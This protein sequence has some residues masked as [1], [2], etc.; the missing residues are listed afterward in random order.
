MLE[1]AAQ[2]ALERIRRDRD[3]AS[4]RLRPML[5]HI[6]SHVFAP[7]LNV[8][9][10]KKACGIRDNSIAILFHSQIGQ[11][12]KTY[13]S[14]RRLET[15]SRLLRDS[16]LRVWKIAE[17]VGYSGLGVFSKA[18]NRWA[19]Q[20]PNAFRRQARDIACAL[21]ASPQPTVEFMDRALSGA[22]TDLEAGRLVERLLEIYPQLSADLAAGTPETDAPADVISTGTGL[23]TGS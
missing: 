5:E 7:G 3:R 17:M 20:R 12:P 6:E 21:P 1:V 11:S 4:Q 10:L 23:A 8:N 2:P 22:L 19:K 13:I 14:E 15:A 16:D 9:H 18:F